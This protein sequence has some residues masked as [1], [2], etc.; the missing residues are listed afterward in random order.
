M[1]Q[2]PQCMTLVAVLVSQPVVTSP[3]QSARP[4]LQVIEHRGG[5]PPHEATPP[6][7]LHGR[8]HAPQ[9]ITLVVRLVSH[10][11]APSQS[12]RSGERHVPDTPHTP[13]TQVAP[14]PTGAWH[15]IPQRPQCATVVRVS[16]SH[17]SAGFMLQSAKPALHPRTEHRPLVHIAVA[18][19]SAQA[20]PHAPQCSE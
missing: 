6:L 11:G 8:P 5:E 16:V 15:I 17:P 18:L 13:A 10:P 2:R 4:V 7:P 20:A 12:P 19:A 14:R 1:P 9:C 3:S